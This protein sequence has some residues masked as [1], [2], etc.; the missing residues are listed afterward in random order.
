MPIRKTLGPTSSAVWQ[1]N[2]HLDSARL[3]LLGLLRQRGR[4]VS[5]QLLQ[6]ARGLQL[7]GG[8]LG[9]SYCLGGFRLLGL[10]L[11]LQERLLLGP[12]V[13]RGGEWDG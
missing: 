11:G 7:S 1:P 2:H 4:L 12:G 5:E 8:V 13:E 6:T 9:G 3:P 10:A